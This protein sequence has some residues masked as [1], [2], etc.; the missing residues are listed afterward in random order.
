MQIHNVRLGFA[1]NSSSQHSMVFLDGQRDRD[2]EDGD[3]G[4][5]RFTAASKEAKGEYFGVLV[6]MALSRM[7]DEHTAR[8]IVSDLLGHK[9]PGENSYIDHQSAYDLPVSWEG[10]GLDLEFA[11]EFRDFL[12]QDGLVILGGNDNS[13]ECHPLLSKAEG[14][15]LAMN[16]DAGYDHL[17]ARKDPSGF[18]TI[19][20]RKTGAK[21]RFRFPKRGEEVSK[22]TYGSAP[23]GKVVPTKTFAPELVDIKITNYCPRK[24]S[25]CYQNSGPGGQHAEWR[26]YGYHISSILGSLRVFEVAIGGGEPT[27]H[28][29]FA[30]ILREFRRH[31]VVPSFSTRDLSWLKD[32]TKWHPILESTGAFAYSVDEPGQSIEEFAAVLNANGFRHELEKLVPQ[33]TVHHVMIGDWMGDFKGFL[34]SAF[35][36]GIHVVLLGHKLAGRGGMANPIKSDDWIKT[37]SELQKADECPRISID[38]TLAKTFSKQ[39][40]KSGIPDWLLEKKEGAF[41]MYVDLVERQIG[42]S[43]FCNNEEKVNL[44]LTQGN[45]VAEKQ[46][47]DAFSSW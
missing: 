31:G 15:S 33:P 39:L 34:R 7:C 22:S 29:D 9:A 13:E 32:P 5:Q 12:L 28:P 35:N 40:K 8:L 44:D 3:F 37:L 41:S 47:L 30:D 18:W 1:T 14:F 21:M 11:K 27:S 43:S 45:K 19:F 46:I 24:C 38:T 16:Q 10:N 36:H 23:D 17:V 20:S 25:F 42:P 2:I 26:H 4:W 6:M